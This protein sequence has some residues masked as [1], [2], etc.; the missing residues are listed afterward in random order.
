M[1]VMSDNDLLNS[2]HTRESLKNQSNLNLSSGSHPGGSQ[3]VAVNRRRDLGQDHRAGAEQ[4]SG[5][6]LR[7]GPSPHRERLRRRV[8]RVQDRVGGVR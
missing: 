6:G 3:Q 4:A 5:Q 8:R 1:L 7:P 2:A